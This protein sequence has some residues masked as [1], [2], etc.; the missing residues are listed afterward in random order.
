MGTASR[1]GGDLRAIGSAGLTPR[2]PG[3]GSGRAIHRLRRG[4]AGRAVCG[5]GFEVQRVRPDGSGLA[6][7][8]VSSSGRVGLSPDGQRIA[9]A[10]AGI[11]VSDLAGQGRLQL[12]TA[13]SGAAHYGPW[14]SPDGGSIA[15]IERRGPNDTIGALPP[16]TF[17]IRV[18]AADGT[19]DHLV[20]RISTP[21]ILT[22]VFPVWSP[23]GSQIAANDGPSSSSSTRRVTT[24]GQSSVLATSGTVRR[25]GF[26]AAGRARLGPADTAFSHSSSRSRSRF[27]TSM[28]AVLLY[29]VSLIRSPACDFFTSDEKFF[30]APAAWI[31]L[32]VFQT[33]T[34]LALRQG[35]DL[36]T[37]RMNERGV[38]LPPPSPACGRGLGVRASLA[39]LR[40]A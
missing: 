24:C 32:I 36:Y 37:S 27:G 25:R 7:L 1:D 40:V 16:Y 38:I 12:T 34:V 11:A 22:D 29:R 20:Y 26:P 9:V 15:Y 33:L 31:R 4:P 6:L 30:R 18:V 21:S 10:D 8:P 5:S 19:G 39:P 35:A 2:R 13:P 3:V 14:W 23:D 28:A 17:D